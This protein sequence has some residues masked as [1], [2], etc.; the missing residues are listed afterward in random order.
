MYYLLKK[1]NSKYERKDTY[2]N[3]CPNINNI[4]K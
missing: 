3:L 4:Y 2:M 1:E